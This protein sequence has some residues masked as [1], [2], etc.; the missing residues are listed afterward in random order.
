MKNHQ[1]GVAADAAPDA[2]S[3]FRRYGA[4]R[5]VFA[6]PRSAVSACT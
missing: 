5:D 6:H 2:G 3:R 1:T 4:T